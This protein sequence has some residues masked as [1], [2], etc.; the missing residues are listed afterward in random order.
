MV[1]YCRANMV[2]FQTRLNVAVLMIHVLLTS[3]VMPRTP[4]ISASVVDV[5]PAQAGQLS[6][7]V[8]SHPP[9][10]TYRFQAAVYRLLEPVRAKDGDI[11]EGA[12]PCAPTKP[13]QP[14]P[15]ILGGGTTWRA[16]GVGTE[17]LQLCESTGVTPTVLSG[18]VLL[19]NAT[20][21]NSTTG[22]W[23]I[24]GLQG[25]DSGQ[26]G[27]CCTS[28]TDQMCLH[29]A[30]PACGF[31]N[32]LFLDNKVFRRSPTL[33]NMSDM[34]WFVHY[35]TP[36]PNGNMFRKSSGTIFFRTHT[37]LHLNLTVGQHATVVKSSLDVVDGSPLPPTVEIS[38]VPHFFL[39]CST[40]SPWC[41]KGIGAS[42]VTLQNVVVEKMAGYAQAAAIMTSCNP[43]DEVANKE[44]CG[45][46]IDGVEV[47]FSH[48]GGIHNTNGAR[49][50]NS[51]VHHNG[52]SGLGGNNGIVDGVE[53]AYNNQAGFSCGWEAGG[54]KWVNHHGAL[55]IQ[56]CFVHHNFGDGLWADVASINMEY[57][58]NIILD[59]AG[60]GISHEISY[61]SIMQG[62]WLSGNGYGFQV[63]LWNGQLQIQNSRNIMI[64]NN[65]V[66]VGKGS[67]NG[68][69]IIQQNRSCIGC[70]LPPPY[71]VPPQ[72]AVNNTIVDNV[73]VFDDCRG[74]VGEI[75]DHYALD[76]ATSGNVFDHN[77]YVFYESES[78]EGTHS[79]F[80]WV[81]ANATSPQGAVGVSLSFKTFQS[82]AHQEQ[83]GEAVYGQ[84]Q[85]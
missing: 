20:L 77:T 33:A 78:E 5:T 41:A 52:Q 39:A 61:D 72:A 14:D 19:T 81:I 16:T 68:I 12:V 24:S 32:D 15:T 54:A 76:L 62:N 51:S 75:A 67:Q 63:W 17:T 59:N 1:P 11:F 21:L 31:V 57:R 82:V 55:V 10:T 79:H 30:R 60:A 36:N 35:D 4:H 69:C 56:N 74:T 64:H 18:A 47:R 66:C 46:T 28:D 6:A 25:L 49:V 13:P 38:M 9:G 29:G 23:T 80:S 7:I 26:H 2:T 50:I 42:N 43:S 34:S 22:M 65:T 8:D 58:N 45:W 84:G 3:A 70:G 48:G 85:C 27:S 71:G 73:V 44:D 83:H 37:N 40:G 53:V